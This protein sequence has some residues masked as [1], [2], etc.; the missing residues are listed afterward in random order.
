MGKENPRLELIQQGSGLD[1]RILSPAKQERWR[2]VCFCIITILDALS[3][4]KLVNG[5]RERSCIMNEML[6]PSL[7]LEPSHLCAS[8]VSSDSPGSSLGHAIAPLGSVQMRG[9]HEQNPPPSHD[10]RSSPFRNGGR[11]HL[12]ASPESPQLIYNPFGSKCVQK[13][14]GAG[15]CGWGGDN[16]G[17]S[18]GPLALGERM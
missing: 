1:A 15:R 12:P 7:A 4:R 6:S 17:T 16:M 2:T 14:Q 8:R 13:N 5:I 9:V 3:D 10:S 11:R 18:R